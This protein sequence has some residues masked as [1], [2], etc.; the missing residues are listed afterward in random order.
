MVHRLEEALAL[1]KQEKYQEA[2]NRS[3]EVTLHEPD[4]TNALMII[5]KSNFS[6]EKV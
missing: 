1:F 5:G 2:I 6:L 4:N 3:Q